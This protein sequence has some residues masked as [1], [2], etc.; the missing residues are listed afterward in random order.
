[1]LKSTA[2]TLTTKE[3]SLSYDS[4]QELLMEP[5]END[6]SGD[7]RAKGADLGSGIKKFF[8]EKRR[9]SHVNVDLNREKYRLFHKQIEGVS[10]QT[11]S[12][13]LKLLD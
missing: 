12:A 2:L 3:T 11:N 6:G 8:P 1:M 7:A 13:V 4:V 5:K 9:L 10:L